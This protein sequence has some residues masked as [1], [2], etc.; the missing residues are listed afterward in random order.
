[1]KRVNSYERGGLESLRI[2]A[3]SCAGLTN[4]LNV[5]GLGRQHFGPFDVC[6]HTQ[7]RTCVSTDKQS[8]CTRKIGRAQGTDQAKQVN[9]EGDSNL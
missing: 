4:G 8:S 3:A 6:S 7:P 5:S 2:H 1:M 9:A